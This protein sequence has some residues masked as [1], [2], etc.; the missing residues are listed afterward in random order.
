MNHVRRLLPIVAILVLLG[1]TGCLQQQFTQSEI[2]FLETRDLDLTYRD[3][4]EACLNA[5]FGMGL[6]ITHTD[7]ESGI[8]TGQSGD[9]A[10]RASVPSYQRKKYAVKKA[11]LM[12]TP[13]SDR[14]TQIRMKVLVNEEQQLDRQLMTEIWQ[15]IER[16]AMLETKPST[17]LTRRP[18]ARRSP[19]RAF[20]GRTSQP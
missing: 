20:N 19:Q 12:V 18:R 4:Y 7:K 16:E 17:T 1:G 14:S 9:Y 3:T 11:T 10:M 13:K 5:M 6:L 15:R 2:K 8:I